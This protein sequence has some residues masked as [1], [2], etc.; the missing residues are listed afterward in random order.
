MKQFIPISYNQWYYSIHNKCKAFA[1]MSKES[2]DRYRK[3]KLTDYGLAKWGTYTHKSQIE[4]Q[5]FNKST[6]V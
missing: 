4:L 6:K 2:L 3:W 1:Y 5:K